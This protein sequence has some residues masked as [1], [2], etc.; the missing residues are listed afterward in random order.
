MTTAW[1]GSPA[2]PTRGCRLAT[3]VRAGLFFAE[4]ATSGRL[5]LDQ[6]LTSAARVAAA[7]LAFAVCG[8]PEKTPWNQEVRPEV[9]ELPLV[10]GD[11]GGVGKVAWV[12]LAIRVRPV[13]GAVF[14]A[15]EED[16]GPVGA[17]A[18]AVGA[19]ARLTTAGACHTGVGVVAAVPAVAGVALAGL[20]VLVLAGGVSP[21][22]VSEVR[23]PPDAVGL[24]APGVTTLI[25]DAFEPDPKMLGSPLNIFPLTIL[26]SPKLLPPD[27]LG[28][29]TGADL[30]VARCTPP[31][32]RTPAWL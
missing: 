24:T 5:V 10:A 13:A 32:G 21:G 19:F 30:A 28:G 23:V 20:M 27:G 3:S 22:V 26:E 12:R 7:R 2:R 29:L 1:A 31:V 17:T 25:F 6:L 18:L 16:A 4:A 9:D 11:C 8:E 15:Q 14:V